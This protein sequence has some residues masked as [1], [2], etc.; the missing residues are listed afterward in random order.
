MALFPVHA[1][2]VDPVPPCACWG[3]GP[4]LAAQGFELALELLRGLQLLVQIPLQLL[5]AVFQTVNLLLRLVHLSL[6]GL[7]AQV[8]LQ[9]KRN[10]RGSDRSNTCRVPVQW[11]GLW[12]SGFWNRW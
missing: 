1:A 6:Q 3:S 12:K 9:G 2:T 11:D 8:Q 5:L 10:A 7:Q 4:H